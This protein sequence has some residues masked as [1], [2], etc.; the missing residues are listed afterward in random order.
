MLGRR[1]ESRTGLK[2]IVIDKDQT[3]YDYRACF[4][5]TSY[6]S[7]KGTLRVQNMLS[8]GKSTCM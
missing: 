5:W 4:S 6:R 2:G 8:P 1:R 3:R 7:M